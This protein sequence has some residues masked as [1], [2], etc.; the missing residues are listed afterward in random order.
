MPEIRLPMESVCHRAPIKI[1][2]NE[3]GGYYCSKCG[4]KADKVYVNPQNFGFMTLVI[5][6]VVIIGILLIIK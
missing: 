4:E 3:F 5:I 2:A 1:T 6:L